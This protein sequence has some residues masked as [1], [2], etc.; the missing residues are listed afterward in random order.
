MIKTYHKRFQRHCSG[1]FGC[2]PAPIIVGKQQRWAHP[3]DVRIAGRVVAEKRFLPVYLLESRNQFAPEP[4][5][6]MDKLVVLVE[7]EG[8]WMVG[9]HQNPASF[10]GCVALY[11]DEQTAR[12]HFNQLCRA[13]ALDKNYS[14]RN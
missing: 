9:T 10:R 7:H 2:D 13:T 12:E 14:P 11:N 8:Q 3:R 5:P 4:G 1:L 6:G